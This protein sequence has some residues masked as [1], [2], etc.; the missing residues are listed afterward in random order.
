MRSE[1]G[2]GGW[3]L[4]RMEAGEKSRQAL[5]ILPAYLLPS[6]TPK[7]PVRAYLLDAACLFC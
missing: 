6:Q 5:W 4:G 7:V 1:M 3:K 2:G